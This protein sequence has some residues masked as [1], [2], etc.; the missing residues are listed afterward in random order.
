MSPNE[1]GAP[2]ERGGWRGTWKSLRGVFAFVAIASAGAFASHCAPVGRYLTIDSMTEVAGNLGAYG[3]LLIAVLGLVT[4]LLFLP[5]WPLAFVS[6]LLYGIAWGTLLSTVASTLG[7]WL[8]YSLSRTFLAPSSDRLRAKYGLQKLT[9]PPERQFAFIFLL[10]AFPLSSF[11]ATNLMAGALSMRPRRYIAA[12]FLGMIPSS[13]MY[14]AWGKLLKKPDGSFY[15][16]AVLVL[17]LM[18]AGILA[19]QKYLRPMLAA[20]KRGGGA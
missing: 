3:P 7:A 11:V 4:P 15:A 1:Q 12:S 20:A 19:A 5:R 18:I 8:H 16:V 17:C 10:R 14:A 2:A 6:G 13:V 9:V